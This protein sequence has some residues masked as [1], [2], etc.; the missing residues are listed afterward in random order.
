[1]ARY[2][3]EKKPKKVVNKEN[4]ANKK[5]KPAQTGTSVAAKFNYSFLTIILIFCLLQVIRSAFINISKVISYN[6]K[7]VQITKTRDA[8]KNL[9]EQLK[10]NINNFSNVSGIEAIARNNLKMSSEDEVLVIINTP[11]EEVKPDKTP[12]KTGFLKHD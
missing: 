8:A 4:Q 3:Q 1:M 6:A 12:K 2:R 9:N 7:I 11:K 5:R 10:D